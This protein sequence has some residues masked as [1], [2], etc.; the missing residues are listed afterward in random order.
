MTKVI[1][2]A[3][4]ITAEKEQLNSQSAIL[5][6]LDLSMAVIEFTPQGDI[7]NANENFLKCMGYKMEEIKGKHHRVSCYD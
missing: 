1:K 6:A 7:L 5:Q 4:D 3:S 2:L